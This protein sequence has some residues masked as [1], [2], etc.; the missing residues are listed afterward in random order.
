VSAQTGARPGERHR[1]VPAS[2]PDAD[3]ACRLTPD[4]GHR[5]QADVD[6]LFA[7]LAEQRETDGGNEFVF[8]GDPET[9]WPEVSAFVDEESRCC[10]FFTFEQVQQ[11]DGVLLRVRHTAP[12]GT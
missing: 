8:R 6:R 1:L 4:E 3:L 7:A 11:A 5:R 12:E 2:E 10:P 9:L